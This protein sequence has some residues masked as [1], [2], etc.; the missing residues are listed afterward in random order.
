MPRAA[1]SSHHAQRRSSRDVLEL[2]GSSST[3]IVDAVRNAIN[4]VSVAPS[5]IQA[6]E[7]VSSDALVG[8]QHELALYK[9]CCR[10]SLRAATPTRSSRSTKAKRAAAPKI[11]G[12][13][14]PK[15]APAQA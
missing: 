5:E 3:S 12:G 14:L 6:I 2:F 13:R 1:R 9:V 10:V 15:A 7:V 4:G 11:G 8:E